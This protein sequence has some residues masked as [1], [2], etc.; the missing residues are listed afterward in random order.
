MAVCKDTSVC[1]RVSM[2]IWGHSREMRRAQPSYQV[3]GS[4]NLGRMIGR[5]VV[6]ES[7]SMAERSVCMLRSGRV[8]GSLL[9]HVG[10]VTGGQRCRPLTMS[11]ATSMVSPPA[12]IDGS[13]LCAIRAVGMNVSNRM[14]IVVWRISNQ[15]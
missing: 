10:D 3:T 9:Y 8:P 5:K 14:V 15:L 2:N 6:K 1:R 13:N 12:C 7:T 4:A 11:P